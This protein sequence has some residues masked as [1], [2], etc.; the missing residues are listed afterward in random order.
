[1]NI[2]HI[3]EYFMRDREDSHGVPQLLREKFQAG[4]YDVKTG[5]GF[6]DYR[7]DKA[8]KATSARDQKLPAIYDA[9][10]GEQK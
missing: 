8:K 4:D 1:M 10:Y 9:I 2:Y 6:Y 7:G 5:K 3:S